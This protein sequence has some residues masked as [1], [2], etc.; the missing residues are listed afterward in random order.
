MTYV[1][2]RRRRPLPS[3]VARTRRPLPYRLRTTENCTSGETGSP[4]DDQS[5]DADVFAGTENRKNA[6]PPPMI[7]TFPADASEIGMTLSG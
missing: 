4:A 1:V 6:A 3:P 2:V 7:D 5:I